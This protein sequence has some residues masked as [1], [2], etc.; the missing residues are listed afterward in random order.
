MNKDKLIRAMAAA[1]YF[2]D[3]INSYDEWLCFNGPYCTTMDF[4]SWEAVELWLNGVVF[5][6]PDVSDAVE[7]IIKEV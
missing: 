3:D 2:Y 6:D 1:D 7:A 5:D 4:D